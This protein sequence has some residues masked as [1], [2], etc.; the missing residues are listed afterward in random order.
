ME[1]PGTVERNVLGT[2]LKLCS[3]TPM[4]GWYRSGF[5]ESCA[6]DRGEHTICVEVDADFLEYSR[7]V[8]NDLSTPMPPYFEGLKPG[9]RWCICASRWVQAYQDGFAPKVMLEAT[10]ESMLDHVDLETLEE[11]AL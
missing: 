6:E 1:M 7:Q 2:P 4:T 11:Y 10:H 3:S 9:D 8:G 5:C